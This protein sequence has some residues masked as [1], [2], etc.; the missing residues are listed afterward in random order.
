MIGAMMFSLAQAAPARADAVEAV[1]RTFKDAC[2][3]G[4]ARLEPVA[5]PVVPPKEAPPALRKWYRGLKTLSFHRLGA[6][7]DDYLVTF[8]G[9]GVGTEYKSGCAVAT[10]RLGLDELWQQVSGQPP[11][12][13]SFSLKVAPITFKHEL[14]R[15]KDGYTVSVERASD[16]YVIAQVSMLNEKDAQRQIAERERND[17]IFQAREARRKQADK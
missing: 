13:D 17:R 6:G 10:K 16:G 1:V 9:S 11:A 5:S 8:V 12:T 4:Q 3:D 14:E 7:S 2:Y 15:L